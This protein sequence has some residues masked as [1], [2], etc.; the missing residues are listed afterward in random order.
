MGM[1]RE[2]LIAVAGDFDELARWATAVINTD[3]D[4][5]AI[6]AF[7]A[8]RELRV[9]KAADKL[10]QTERAEAEAAALPKVV[11]FMAEKIIGRPGRPRVSPYA[12]IDREMAVEADRR[13]RQCGRT[14]KPM[15]IIREVVSQRA[16]LG[17]TIG[18]GTHRCHC[19]AR[20][21]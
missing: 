19:Q 11:A 15:A 8:A 18:G 2:L 12:E 4:A 10:R 6:G 1:L 5:S 21:H 7:E 17:V 16:A 14:R 13:F 3:D 9:I 20:I